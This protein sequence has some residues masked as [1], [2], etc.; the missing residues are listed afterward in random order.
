MT[1]TEILSQL[2][3]HGISLRVE[4]HSLRYHAPKSALTPDLRKLLTENRDNI[5]SYLEK[6]SKSADISERIAVI[7]MAGRASMETNLR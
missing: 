6:G 3:Q 1:V 4:N 2:T 5:I 7:G